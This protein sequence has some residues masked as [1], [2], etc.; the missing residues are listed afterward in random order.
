[1]VVEDLETFRDGER[2][3]AEELPADVL[4]TKK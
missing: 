4:D 1:V 3:H 2:V